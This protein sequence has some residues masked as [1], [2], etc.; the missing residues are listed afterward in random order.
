MLYKKYSYFELKWGFLLIFTHIITYPTICGDDT[1]DMN[2]LTNLTKVWLSELTTRGCSSNTIDLYSR[3]MK[4]LNRFLAKDT[5]VKQVEVS[6]ITR[7]QLILA[8]SDYRER[9]D[10]RTWKPVQRSGQSV[11]NYYTTVKSFLN[12]RDS[13]DHLIQNPMKSVKSPQSRSESH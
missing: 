10:G 6:N 9:N 13:S 8:L 2:N 5:K 11:M 1:I 3:N 12:W 4:E 7:E